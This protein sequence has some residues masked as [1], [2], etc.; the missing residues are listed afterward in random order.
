MGIFFL[1]NR[2]GYPKPKWESWENLTNCPRYIRNFLEKV[3]RIASPIEVRKI[4]RKIDN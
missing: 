2:V 3:E 4:F 1:L